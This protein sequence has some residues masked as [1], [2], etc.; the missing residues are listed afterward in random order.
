MSTP[1]VVLRVIDGPHAGR[2]FEF[3]QHDSLLA[4]RAIEAQLCLN[5]DQHF[6]RNHFRI[7]IA[8]PDCRLI[9]LESMNGTFVNGERVDSAWLRNGDTISGGHTQIQ[10]RVEGST[11]LELTPAVEHTVIGFFNETEET[12]TRFGD[13][14]LDSELGR[15]AMG[16]VY[17]AHNS[18]FERVALKVIAPR[19]KGVETAAACFVREANILR[20]L[21][22]KRIVKFVD[23]GLHEGSIFLAM[24]YIPTIDLKKFLKT[25]SIETRMRAVCAI[26]SQ[27]LD[28]LH[29][30]HEQNFVH[31]DIKPRNILVSY[32]DEKLRAHIAD[33]GLAKNFMEAGLSQISGENEIKGTLPFMAPEQIISCRYAKPSADIFS[34]AATAYT[35]ITGKRIY[36]LE[37]HKTP[38]A[39]VL[40]QGP[41]PIR[42][43]NPAVP[44][45]L[46]AI[47]HR[48][49][50]RDPERRYS[51]AADMRRAL[52][53]YTRKKANA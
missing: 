48:G 31:R 44:K 13:W 20:Q 16:I 18:Q 12:A 6:S 47:I 7:E 34:C 37:N 8:P 15:G 17:R 32:E 45:T 49:L 19:Q 41:I 22:H 46:A 5:K 23:G 27:V 39:A 29:Y 14:Y 38:I 11:E 28:G 36:D 52:Q 24:E 9:D 53:A 26:M 51:S 33:F 10:V 25:F 2:V 30:A 40:N 3:D 43:R 50:E 4:G 42:D 35:L 21:N 1:R